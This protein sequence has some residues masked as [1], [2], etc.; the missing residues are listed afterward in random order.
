MINQLQ[1]IVSVVTWSV[2]CSAALSFTVW[3][4][5]GFF[6]FILH[7]HHKLHALATMKKATG[8]EAVYLTLL[9]HTSLSLTNSLAD[10]VIRLFTY[11]KV[12]K[13]QQI[14]Y[15]LYHFNTDAFM[16]LSVVAARAS[17]IHF[18]Q[19]DS[20]GLRFPN[21]GSR[22]SKGDQDKSEGTWDDGWFGQLW[23]HKSLSERKSILLWTAT[24][25]RRLQHV[26]RPDIEY[27]DY[28]FICRL[29]F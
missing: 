23:N 18:K 14:K 21:Y 4:M 25:H 15:W 5:G 9:P 16:F 20:V 28:W 22:P 17:L 29:S 6:F 26:E 3:T 10:N 19:V 11:L 1:L 2:A 13:L 24:T 12:I 7:L 27:F 8:G